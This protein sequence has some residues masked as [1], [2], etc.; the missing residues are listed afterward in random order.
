MK[1][2]I[3]SRWDDAQVIASGE[4]E[5][6]KEFL[7]TQV[8]DG[9][10]LSRANLDG[11][12]ISSERTAVACLQIAPLGSRRS[13]LIAWLCDDQSILIWTGCFR[14]S[15][16]KFQD[17]VTRTHKDNVYAR[18]YQAAIVFVLAWAAL[19]KEMNQQ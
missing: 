8:K 5:S 6:L 2:E 14:D 3:K 19:Q 9:A 10:N 17:T 4:A 12:K 7:E 18:E 13:E 16:D 15:L 1:I 11:A